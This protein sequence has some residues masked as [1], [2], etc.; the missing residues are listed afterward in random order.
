MELNIFIHR[1]S[2]SAFTFHTDVIPVSIY[3]KVLSDNY[4]YSEYSIMLYILY[5]ALKKDRL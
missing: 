2:P 3:T 1:Y 4:N 5:I